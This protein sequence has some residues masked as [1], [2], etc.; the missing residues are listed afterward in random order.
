[1]LGFRRLSE[2]APFLPIFPGLD[3]TESLRRV[4][5]ALPEGVFVTDREG[6]VTFWNRG[7]ER[8][9]GW[10]RD[11]A[12]GQ[13]CSLLAGDYVNGCTCGAGLLYCG[14][15]ERSRTSRRCTLRTRDGRPQAIVKNAIALY[16]ADGTP[17]GTLETFTDVDPGPE[18]TCGLGGAVAATAP[19]DLCGLV[20]RHPAMLELYR[21]IRLVARS[22]ATVMITGESGTGKDRIA[23][24]IH[25]LGDRA[26]GPLIRYSCAALDPGAVEGELFGTA[27]GRRG[28]IA[29]AER[30]TLLLD[31]VS[32]AP[33][34]L[35][36]KLLRLVE[37]RTI[38]ARDA[39]PIPADVRIL[40]TTQR[41]LR[42]LVQEGRFR[43]DLYF[44]LAA[45]PLHVPALRERIEDVQLLAERF[46]ADLRAAG[47]AVGT[48]SPQTLR[49]L[50]AYPWP[51]N[52][53]ELRN[54]IE[55]A[56]L[57]AGAGEISPEHLPRDILE[58][59]AGPGQPCD[60]DVDARRALVQALE[61]T[62]WNRTR[63]A[64]LLGV[65]RV[66]LWKRMRRLGVADPGER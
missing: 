65:S 19:G 59:R 56:A 38:A 21:M 61:R 4:A 15:A 37:D 23:E 36:A 44:R 14:I 26:S 42:H 58:F 29:N 43:A 8:I 28:R 51:G 22:S 9:T 20:G 47:Q 50:R 45:F 49:V 11:E 62:G 35:Q 40:C 16:A 53:R 30:G 39:N 6:K 25:V 64:E 32:G 41:D 3:S 55:Y 31:E 57:L 60:P 33:P 2:L 5:D 46:L 27:D 12:I 18:L 1:M 63:A 10:S 48:L 7:A 52:V 66:T 54:T 17:V 24:A 34:A 13:R